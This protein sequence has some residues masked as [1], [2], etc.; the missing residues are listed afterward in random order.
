VP[1]VSGVGE[2]AMLTAFSILSLFFAFQCLLLHSFFQLSL[3]DLTYRPTFHI[4]LTH[5]DKLLWC[6]FFWSWQEI[7][8]RV[9]L[10]VKCK[11][12]SLLYSVC[13]LMYISLTLS[14]EC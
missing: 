4:C 1:L 10:E 14:S 2:V 13:S 9:N 12:Q 11:C 5:A 8:R 7:A 3:T 6:F